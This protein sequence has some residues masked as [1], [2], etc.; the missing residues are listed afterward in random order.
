MNT[1]S[2]FSIFSGKYFNQNLICAILGY[3]GVHFALKHSH[4]CLCCICM[5]FFVLS[6]ISVIVSLGFYTWEYCHRKAT[7]AKSHQIRYEYSTKITGAQKGLETFQESK[8]PIY[9][10]PKDIVS[11]E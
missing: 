8:N 5:V 7:K 6:V 11:W 9:I 2:L 1:N 10:L 3:L 4:Q